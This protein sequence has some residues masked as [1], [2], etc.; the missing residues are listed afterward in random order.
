V[1]EG[2]SGRCVAACK[3]GWTRKEGKCSENIAAVAAAVVAAPAGVIAA[4][5]GA[6]PPAAVAAAIAGAPRAAS[7]KIEAVV[8]AAP[9]AV[10]NAIAAA[11]GPSDS[12]RNKRNAQNAILFGQLFHR[13]LKEHRSAKGFDKNKIL[14]HVNFA[15]YK[16]HASLY[17]SFKLKNNIPKGAAA[18]VAAV[19][20]AKK[21]SVKILLNQKPA[22]RK[23]RKDA[24][25][26]LAKG[27]VAEIVKVASNVP[28]VAA[29][30]IINKI[31]SPQKAAE[32]LEKVSE[33]V[34]S[35]KAAE[36]AK[37]V[38]LK[39]PSADKEDFEFGKGWN[40]YAPVPRKDAA[41]I[42]AHNKEKAEKRLAY[43][44]QQARR[45]AR[46]PKPAAGWGWGFL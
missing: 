7:A 13:G 34:S 23:E 6:A 27:P 1:P 45:A 12:Y 3:S 22:T 4:I 39:A 28:A 43:N 5:I 16:P 42:Q 8:A 37:S 26:A 19:P 38:S 18:A 30:E 9:A 41:E 29:A 46:K 33:K 40:A 31:S 44:A 17:N 36:I 35:P 24:A 32:V 20:A 14:S 2:K 21:E 11:E 25:R 10:A 15:S